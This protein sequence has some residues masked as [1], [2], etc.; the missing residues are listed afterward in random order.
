MSHA[1]YLGV[2]SASL[3]GSLHCVGMCGPFVGF[4]SG[5]DASTGAKR[6]LSHVAYHSGRLVTY[7]ALGAVAGSVGRAL[8]LAGNAAGIARAAAIVAGL[9]MVAW[10]A[11]LLLESGGVR[12]GRFLPRALIERA[13]C[14]LARLRD[15]PPIARALVIGLSST[16]LPCGWLYAFAVTAAGTGSALGGATLMAVFW[17][18]TLPLLLGLGVGVQRLGSRLRQHLPLVTALALV[19]LGVVSVI[20]RVD[21]RAFAVGQDKPSCHSQAP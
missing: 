21:A 12:V 5:G 7:A 16:L 1:L 2:F 4:Y 18:G 17:L 13:G 19:A 15:R 6:V 20:G 3:L 14:S 8:D 10:G 9:V 11:V